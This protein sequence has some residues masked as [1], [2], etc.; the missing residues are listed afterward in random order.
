[1]R[2]VAKIAIHPGKVLA[3]EIDYLNMSQ[4]DLANKAGVSGKLI[5]DIINGKAL[6]S[7]SLASALEDVIGGSSDF[8][9][10]LCSNYE[11][12]LNDNRKIKCAQKDSIRYK[13]LIKNA[14]SELLK[15]GMVDK[16]NRTYE[17]IIELK[18]Y[19]GVTTLDDL[20]RFTKIAFR[21]NNNRQIDPY[22][23]AAWLKYGDK[24][25]IA[26]SDVKEYDQNKLRACLPVI[27]KEVLYTNEDSLKKVKEILA[28]CGVILIPT[29]LFKCT[30]TNGASRWIRNNPIIQL[31]DRNKT[32]DVVWFT[33]FHEI[34]HILKHGKK[35]EFVNFD[36]KYEKSE[37]E[38]EADSF[39]SEQLISEKI[40]C[41]FVN[42]YCKIAPISHSDIESY[43]KDNE[44]SKS[45]LVGRLQRDGYVDYRKFNDYKTTIIM[46]TTI[47]F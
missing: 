7:P 16:V 28:E 45:I 2:Y 30:Y 47:S 35:D 15:V 34:G 21:Q 13:E 20:P 37:K 40:Y 24:I 44:I 8:W 25:A 42:N 31:S 14:Y 33:L 5:S 3:R 6:I 19:F 1:M 32:D 41:T 22:S 11:S 39:A 4:K 23:L 29:K 38:K 10:A 9:L 17:K 36:C 27:K 43:C 12:T 26:I 18:K 46:D